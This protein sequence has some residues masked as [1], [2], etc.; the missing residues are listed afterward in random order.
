M[1]IVEKNSKKWIIEIAENICVVSTHLGTE[2]VFFAG[3]QPKNK[4]V[5]N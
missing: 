1:M 2:I 5:L 4:D 3:L